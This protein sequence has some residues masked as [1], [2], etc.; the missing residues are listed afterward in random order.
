ML[1]QGANITCKPLVRVNILLLL[2]PTNMLIFAY[3][4]W[5][6]VPADIVAASIAAVVTVDDA[7][8]L[9]ATVILS[10]PS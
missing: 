1:E 10:L 5:K 3:D 4:L 7:A 9:A 8:L 2:R 6:C